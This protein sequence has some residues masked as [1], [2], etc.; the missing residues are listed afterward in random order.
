MQRLLYNDCLNFIFEDLFSVTKGRNDMYGKTKFRNK[1]I[2]KCQTS[3]NMH[4][5]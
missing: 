1:P 3:F 5:G 2:F 4:G